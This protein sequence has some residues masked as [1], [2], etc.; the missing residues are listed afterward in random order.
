MFEALKRNIEYDVAHRIMH[1]SIQRAPVA[2]QP[3]NLA[4]NQAG[5]ANTSPQRRRKIGRN[6]P[7]WCGSG[8]KFKQ[9]H[10]APEVAR[11]S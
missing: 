7:C 8:K 3:R 11:T 1:A 10:G 4:T 5:E 6:D 9:C 2:A